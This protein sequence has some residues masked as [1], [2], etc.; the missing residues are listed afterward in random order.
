M[1]EP[2][3]EPKNPIDFSTSPACLLQAGSKSNDYVSLNAKLLYKI[4]I[5]H[6]PTVGDQEGLRKLKLNVT[7]DALP[8]GKLF[9]ID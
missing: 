8:F 4:S 9:R 2:S 7:T 3:R 5:T 1:F 6:V